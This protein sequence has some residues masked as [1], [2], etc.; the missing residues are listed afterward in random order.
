MSPRVCTGTLFS[1]FISDMDSGIKCTLSKFADDPNL[2]D[3][4]GTLE[5]RDAIQADLDRLE[6]WAH[7]NFMKFNKAKC[8][9]RHLSWGN[10]KHRNR[11]DR[12]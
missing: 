5:G 9:I 11:L 8:K 7:A 4:G 2:S 3:A 12:D 10:S 6:R 1:S